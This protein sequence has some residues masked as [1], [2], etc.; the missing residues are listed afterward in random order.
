MP[1]TTT[2]ECSGCPPL[3]ALTF[4]SLGL[5]KVV[6]ARDKQRA[7]PQ[8]V[9]RWGEPES[10]KCVMAVS[11]IDRNSQPLLAV[12]RKNNEIE[13]LSPVNGDIQTTISDAS[14]LDDRT[15]ENNI[16]GLHLFGKQ[17][18]ELD[19]R[20]CTLLTCTTKGNASI[21]SIEL[22][23]PSTR[24]SCI[25]SPKTWNVCSG[26]NILCCKVD[27]DENFA[28]F[29][30]KGV[31]INIWD[32]NNLTKIWNSKPPPKNNLGIFTPT[33]FTSAAFLTKDDHR[34][35]VAGTNS[36]QVRLYDIS[37][38]RRP[39]LSFDFRETPI[40]ALA[41]DIDGHSVY[42]GNGSGD[43]ASFDIRTGKMLGGFSGK[44]SGSI[45]SIVRHPELPIVASCG[46]DCYLRLWDTKTRQLLSA[47]F[48]KQHIMHVLFDSKF[49]LKGV[50]SSLPS[51]EKT[52]TEMIPSEEVEELPLKRKKS[53][54]NKE[55]TEDG[56]ERKKKS[57]HSKERKKSEGK[58]EGEKIGSR[59]ERRKSKLKKKKS[60]SISE[61]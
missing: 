22:A 6:E 52:Q 47:V 23:D 26:G 49:D 20:Y 3:R 25:D 59:D 60:S 53:S 43:M 34:K 13:V 14:G 55:H 24:S 2:L 5:I 54:R 40:K 29:G 7:I 36:H 48:L 19:S 38:Q 35:F 31:E 32:I 33:W 39:V 4:D 28:L 58:D 50:D 21:R 27:R 11:M 8:V 45:K 16:V 57:K 9:E 61:L 30:G 17:N 44:C 51:K 10:S 56:S 12:A 15:E 42:V 1:R 18:S 46:L 41:E 37:A